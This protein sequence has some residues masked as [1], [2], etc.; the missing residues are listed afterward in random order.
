MFTLKTEIISNFF[1]SKD[2][3][4]RERL[5]GTCSV[6]SDRERAAK[7]PFNTSALTGKACL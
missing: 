6:D 2:K 5:L 3:D 7:Y 1:Y 4:F